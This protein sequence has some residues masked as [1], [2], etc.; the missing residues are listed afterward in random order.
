MQV[1]D[2]SS[3]R[4]LSTEEQSYAAHCLS[5]LFPDYIFRIYVGPKLDADSYVYVSSDK[6][7]KDE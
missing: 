2:G 3:W 6:D 4:G 7:M 5:K 1:H